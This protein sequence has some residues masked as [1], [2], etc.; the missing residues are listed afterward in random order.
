MVSAAESGSSPL[1]FAA[2]AFAGQTCSC[3]CTPP[4]GLYG[5]RDLSCPTRQLSSS[6]ALQGVVQQRMRLRGQSNRETPF[7]A[8][9]EAAQSATAWAACPLWEQVRMPSEA[10]APTPLPCARSASL[11]NHHLD[12]R[13][14]AASSS[15]TRA[16][17][18]EAYRFVCSSRAVGPA[19]HQRLS[20]RVQGPAHASPACIPPAPRAAAGPPPR[21]HA[22][23]TRQI[24]PPQPRLPGRRRRGRGTGPTLPPQARAAAPPLGMSKSCWGALIRLPAPCVAVR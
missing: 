17:R 10:A 7:N 6:S 5:H 8:G 15:A 2:V 12:S 11:N 14:T 13:A 18:A 21:P 3:M 23:G 20:G 9:M 19:A 22:A 4:A 16:S 24:R 1:L